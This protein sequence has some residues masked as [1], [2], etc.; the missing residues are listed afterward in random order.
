MRRSACPLVYRLAGSPSLADAQ[1]ALYTV[2]GAVCAVCGEHADTTAMMDRIAG[3][4]FTDQYWLADPKSDRICTACG[5]VLTGRPPRT[6]RMWTI[7]AAPGRDLPPSNPK[8]WLQGTPG[9]MLTSRGATRPVVDI[10]TSPPINDPWVV[11]VAISGQKH[12]LPFAEVNHGAGRWQVRMETT[13][14]TSDPAEFAAVLSHARA[15]RAAGHP[16]DAVLAL[17]PRPV[18]TRDELDTWISHADPLAPYRG[19]PLLELA[20]WGLTREMING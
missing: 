11:S 2:G 15:L 18:K 8:A 17:S 7:V 19:S 4:N 9:L 1:A 14:V 16:A 5:W 13:T 6:L 10:L 12:V 20:L 3:K